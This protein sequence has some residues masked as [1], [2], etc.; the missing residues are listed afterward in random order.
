MNGILCVWSSIALLMCC[1]QEYGPKAWQKRVEAGVLGERIDARSVDK[2][3][4]TVSD[5]RAAVEKAERV[6]GVPRGTRGVTSELI[7]VKD[8]NTPFLASKLEHKTLWQVVV[9]DWKLDSPSAPPAERENSRTRTF[10]VLVRPED[11]RV[12]KV[13]SRWPQGETMM[14]P[15]P[16]GVEKTCVLYGSGHTTYHDFGDKDPPVNLYEALVSLYR[17]GCGGQPLTAKQILAIPVMWSNCGH[18]T[19]RLVWVIN[20]RGVMPS[21]TIEENPEPKYEW[22]YIVDAETGE[23]LLAGNVLE[24][25]EVFQNWAETAGN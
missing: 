4:W 24:P 15:E 18:Q 2:S 13:R 14:A 3:N 6:L 20:L 5:A 1:G 17:A 7:K 8:D 22:N 10:D 16:S 11:G 12:V 19:P 25:R 21:F 9:Y 23:P